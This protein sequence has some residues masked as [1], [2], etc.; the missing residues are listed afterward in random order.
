MELHVH[1][2]DVKQCRHMQYQIHKPLTVHSKQPILTMP[3]TIATA[4]TVKVVASAATE[5]K[6]SPKSKIPLDLA[7]NVHY[8]IA[9]KSTRDHFLKPATR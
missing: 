3:S 1:W 4:L 2:C 8:P 9:L 5:A 6:N 7:A